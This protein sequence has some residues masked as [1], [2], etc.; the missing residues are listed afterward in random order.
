MP[1]QT[2]YKDILFNPNQTVVRCPWCDNPAVVRAF[3]VQIGFDNEHIVY[4]QAE[5]IGCGGVTTRPG[6]RS[7]SRSIF[8]IELVDISFRWDTIDCNMVV[9]GRGRTTTTKCNLENNEMPQL[10]RPGRD[11]TIYIVTK[12]E[13]KDYHIIQ[14]YSHATPANYLAERSP[15]VRVERMACSGAPSSTGEPFKVYVISVGEN[16]RYRIVDVSADKKRAMKIATSIRG[17]VSEF[18]ARPGEMTYNEVR[19]YKYFVVLGQDRRER[20]SSR[21]NVFYVDRFTRRVPLCEGQE[22][23]P[24]ATRRRRYNSSLPYRLEVAAT[25]Q[26]LAAEI[27]QNLRARLT[28]NDIASMFGYN[29]DNS[30]FKNESGNWEI[31]P[32]LLEAANVQ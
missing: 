13:G 5:C 12:G 27:A 9:E 21:E 23:P 25:S 15:D 30:L 31:E 19:Y 20:G 1:E 22:A 29:E 10:P 18:I 2:N 28:D 11:R 17:A 4:G 24:I 3:D 16:E 14:V 6:G 7:G 8:E 32:C 26:E